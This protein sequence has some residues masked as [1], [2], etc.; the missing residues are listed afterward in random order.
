MT[1][2][3][4]SDLSPT[5]LVEKIRQEIFESTKLT[6]SAGIACN[7]T[8]AKVCS[9]YNKPNGQ[10]YLPI[11][12]KAAV[13]NFV[14]DLKLRNIP[15]VGRVTERVLESLGV[16]TCGDI[17]PRRA[18]LYKLLSPISFQFM[19]RS[20]LG[21]GNTSFNA[22]EERKSMSVERTFSA[23][24]NET[25]LCQKL[26]ELSLH[27]EKDLEKSNMMGRNIGIKLK[28]VT[29]EVKIRSQTLPTY[30]WTAKD[31]ER[32]AKALLLK[33]LPVNIRLMGIRMS[34]MKQRGTED[35]SV[36]K[37]FTKLP[38]PE[39]DPRKQDIRRKEEDGIVNDIP[40]A[41]YLPKVEKSAQEALPTLIC[42]ICNR[43]LILDNSS[44]NK[45]VDE[46]LS[47][48]EVKAILKDQLEK[49]RAES[50]SSESSSNQPSLKRVKRSNTKAKHSKGKSL[51]DYYSPS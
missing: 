45:H 35:Q 18:L 48:V 8:L 29:F 39:V 11:D 28:M 51:L 40:A 31:I 47:G 4:T 50:T 42:P 6:A 14:K 41:D 16:T 19:L 13:L 15:G 32:I 3:K 21:L 44:F 43:Q 30:V 26:K 17:Y 7:R 46:C 2:L 1:Y 38:L 34:T 22:D 12:S 27:L 5:Q 20:Y 37:Y 10:Y 23:M 9:D 25:E 36:M 33:E 49:E 24:S